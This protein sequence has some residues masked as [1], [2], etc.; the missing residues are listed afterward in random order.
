MNILHPHINIKARQLFE[1][2]HQGRKIDVKASRG[3]LEE[4][5]DLYLEHLAKHI[6]HI[7]SPRDKKRIWTII[8]RNNAVAKVLSSPQYRSAV[9]KKNQLM[10]AISLGY[11]ICIDGRIPAIF[12]GGRHTKHFE[13]PASEISVIKRKSDKHIIPDSTDLNEGLRKIATS[14]EELLELVFAHTSLLN[15]Q[16]GCG[17]MA[18]KRKA[19][20]LDPKLTNEEA[21]LKIIEEKTIPAIS[22]IFNEFKTQLGLE[23][24]TVVALPAVYDTDTFG[25]ILNYSSD[26]P[27]STTNLTKEY[28]DHLDDYLIKYNLVFGSFRERFTDLKYLAKFNEQILKIT[29]SI[30]DKKVA[31]ELLEEVENYIKTHF[32]DLSNTQSKAL[33]YIILRT[34]AFQ[35]LTGLCNTRRKNLDHAF[36]EHEETF[37]AVAM[38]GGTIG[39]YDPEDQGF[40]ST[41]SDPAEAISN[42]KTMLSIMGN[43]PKIKPYLLFVCNSV[44]ARDLKENDVVVQRLMGS[45]AGLLR[46]IIADKQLGELIESGEMIPVP[47]LVEEGTREVLKI[48]DHAAYI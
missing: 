13:V 6:G 4:Q 25:I 35:Y 22:N 16:H 45:N 36:A 42:I 26:H 44:S 48:A 3:L 40:A 18:G 32:S 12:L 9:K 31:I 11:V 47:V 34:V 43:F 46:D 19:G 23:P 20:F 7:V 29:E 27:L 24:Q 2:I 38:R 1:R 41:P 8:A 30:L 10:G 5:L 17:A 39:K 37:M 21:N 14:G 28:Q 15:P 33:K